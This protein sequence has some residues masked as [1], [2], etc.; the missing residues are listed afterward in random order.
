ML[1]VKKYLKISSAG[2]PS[3]IKLLKKNGKNPTQLLSYETH[4][5]HCILSNENKAM[6]VGNYTA[7]L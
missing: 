1:C 7:S 4:S 5:G 2:I 6:A 3:K